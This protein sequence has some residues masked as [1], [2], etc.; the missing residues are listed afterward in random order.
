MNVTTFYS[1]KGQYIGFN[2]IG[3]SGYAQQGEDIVCAAISV[4]TQ[5]TVN[6]LEYF[7]GI[8]NLNCKLNEKNGEIKLRLA[9][10]LEQNAMHDA[11]VLLQALYLGLVNLQETYPNYIKILTEEVF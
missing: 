1:N 6:A 5:N 10:A 7:I 2:S 11:Q 8:K 4:L 3:H 9:D